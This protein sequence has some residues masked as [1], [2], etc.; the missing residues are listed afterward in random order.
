M[1]PGL[2]VICSYLIVI[3]AGTVLL[4]IPAASTGGAL[5]PIDALFSATSALCVTGLTVV[6]TGTRFT[7]FGKSVI[8]VLIQLGGLGVMT[9]SVFL[10]LFLGRGLGTRGRWII[11]ES[12]TPAPIREV[13]NL[14]RSVFLFTFIMEGAGAVLLYLFWRREMHA[15]AAIFASVFHS[16]SAFCNAGFSF[17]ATSF[18][19]YRG[20][21]LLNGTILALI[22]I[23]GIG[24]PVIYELARRVSIRRRRRRAT[25][26]LHSR[27]VLSTTAILIASGGVLFYLLERGNAV[28]ALPWREKLLGALFQSVTAR[29]AGFNTLDVSSLTGAT[30]FILIMLMF[31]GA[32]PGSC[33]G[34]IKTTSLAVFSAIF[35]SRVRGR[36]TVSIFH[37]TLPEETVSRTFS[38]FILAVVTV[39]AGVILLL[40]T[41]LHAGDPGRERF[42]AYVFEAV[43][44]FGT[45]GLSMG[46]TA[47]LAGPGKLVLIVLMFV[48]RVGLLTIAYVVTRRQRLGTYRYAEEKV[49]IG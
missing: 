5:T 17:F 21:L 43:S 41:G 12:F 40:V 28:A 9:F 22:V 27:M 33:G 19:R 32:S 18:E 3:L 10:F 38:I 29:T 26:S 23:G 35:K 30:L 24:F 4:S 46:V 6:D 8:L 13:G 16:V 44:A 7:V 48:G 37:R 49:M 39:T 2:L 11:T 20:S 15:P 14:L 34:G 42:L 31:I 25:L 36:D 45:V 47:T 1:P